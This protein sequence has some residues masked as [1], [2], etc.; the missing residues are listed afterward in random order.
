[1]KKILYISNIQVPYRVHFFNELSKKCDLT[2][3][4]ERRNSKNRDNKWAKSKNNMYK[5]IFLDG[6]KI[7]N[8]EGFSLKIIKYLL[9]DYD[10]IVLGCYNS[11]IQMFANI[12]LRIL[13]KPF[14][15]NLDGE[16]FAEGNNV[17]SIIKRF[18]IKGAT[19]YLIAGECA[20]QSLKKIVNTKEIY[21]YYFSSITK[22]ELL[23]NANLQR[24]REG[25]V[26]VVGQYEKY[27]GLDIAV[28]VA[29]R[30]PNIVFKFIGMGNKTDLFI[31]ENNIKNLHN[32]EVL[33]FLQKKELEE[34][35]KKCKIFLLPSRQECWGLVINEAASFGIP[36]IS[37]TGSGAAV[38]FLSEEYKNFLIEAENVDELIKA[39][40]EIWDMKDLNEYSRYLIEKSKK[41]NIEDSVKYHLKAFGCI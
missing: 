15:I 34:E 36:I 16:I 21:P 22:E 5:I 20:A 13:R 3:L 12:F 31:K 1:M 11:P 8:E 19:K 18:F 35:Y 6:F 26:L 41:Y 23:K 39:V 37:T 2:V 7:G 40:K 28:E 4:Y 14:F 29:K 24:K 10:E 33:S 30:L 25:T 17:K 9:G 38:E 27:K 32:V